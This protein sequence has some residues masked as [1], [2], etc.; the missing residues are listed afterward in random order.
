MQLEEIRAEMEQELTWRQ[1]EIVFL[2]NVMMGIEKEEDKEKYRKYLVVMLYAHFE[3][4]CKTCLLI[5]V[6][7]INDLNL[8]RNEVNDCL[9]ASSMEGIFNGYDN[10]DRKCK[11]FK[12]ELPDDTDFHRFYRRTDL[13]LQFNEFLNEKLVIADNVINTES[14]LWYHVLKKNLF[15][16]GI[17]YTVFDQYKSS[18]NILVNKRNSIAH[19]SEKFGVP[20][21]DYKKIQDDII[22][23]MDNIIKIL[24]KNLQDESFKKIS[25]N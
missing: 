4:F 25:S 2:K 8:T 3:G 10:L 6:K 15:K 11:V 18:I 16:L 13:V 23:A 20:E 5:Y 14:N 19:G 12:R 21:N 22:K 24:M 1:H 9:V 17:D 7:A